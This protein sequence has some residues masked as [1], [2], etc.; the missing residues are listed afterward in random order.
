MLSYWQRFCQR[1]VA[2]CRVSGREKVIPGEA[3]PMFL[4]DLKQLLEQAMPGTNSTAKEQ[5]LLHHLVASLPPS[6]QQAV[7]IGKY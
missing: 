5:L 2:P 3:L 6:D 1:A 4:H 7:G